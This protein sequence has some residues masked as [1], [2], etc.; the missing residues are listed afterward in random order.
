MIYLKNSKKFW[1]FYSAIQL[2]L[3]QI[4]QSNYNEINILDNDNNLLT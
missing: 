1:I 2:E 3:N 4:N